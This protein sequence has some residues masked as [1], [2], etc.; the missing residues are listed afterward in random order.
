MSLI[1][2]MK[3][4]AKATSNW[5]RGKKEDRS[6]TV[7]PTMATP[8]GTLGAKAMDRRGMRKLVVSPEELAALVGKGARQYPRMLHI[9]KPLIRNPIF[10]ALSQ[11]GL[12]T[13]DHMP[14]MVAPRKGV[15]RVIGANK[16][17]RMADEMGINN[18]ERRRL[19]AAFKNEHRAVC[20]A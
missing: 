12:P 14:L 1:D 19:R 16:L 18:K 20:P 13:G 17:K 10:E 8:Y 11:L 5:L 6:T 9:S 3:R 15:T 2:S 7:P 4:A